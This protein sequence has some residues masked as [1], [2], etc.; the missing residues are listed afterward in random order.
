MSRR[1]AILVGADGEPTALMRHARTQTRRVTRHWRGS[2]GR[3]VGEAGVG[4]VGRNRV[5]RR[6]VGVGRDG[7]GVMTHVGGFDRGR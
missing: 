4:N 6:R 3:R 7:V 2:I 5:E 1:P